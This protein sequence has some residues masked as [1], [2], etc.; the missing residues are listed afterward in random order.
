MEKDEIGKSIVKFL[1]TKAQTDERAK[2]VPFEWPVRSNGFIA[3]EN[4]AV[5]LRELIQ[6]DH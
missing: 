3:K 6:K 5:D 1:N 4:C 2:I